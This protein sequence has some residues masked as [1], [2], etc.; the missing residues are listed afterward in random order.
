MIGANFGKA[1]IFSQEP[2]AGMNRCGVASQGGGDD[3]G[4]VEVAFAAGGL[5]NADAF[6]RELD[7]EG[8]FVNGGM[9]GHS[10]DPQFLT[11]AE[12]TKGDFTPIGNED[13][14][15]LHSV[16]QQWLSVVQSTIQFLGSSAL[17]FGVAVLLGEFRGG[18]IATP[19]PP[20]LLTFAMIKLLPFAPIVFAHHRSATIEP[21]PLG[22]VWRCTAAG[23]VKIQGVEG[24]FCPG[25]GERLER[26]HANIC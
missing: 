16:T 25:G 8:V 11:T 18:A 13:F 24:R 26:F 5:A 2:I 19:G 6:V 17:V 7:M 3:V 15:K 12:N 23:T 10:G 20:G 1:G 22:L 14:R 9:D 21:D 4:N